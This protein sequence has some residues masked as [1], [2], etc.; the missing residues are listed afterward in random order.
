MS[1]EIRT[2]L[3]AIAGVSQL[4]KRSGL[5]DKQQVQV[6]KIENAGRH[7]LEII[8]A[9]LDLSKIEAGKFALEEEALNI[10][11]ILSN[12]TSMLVDRAHAKQLKLVIEAP[13]LPRHLLGDA[14]RI[15]QAL[16]NYLTN[17]IKFTDSGTVTLRVQIAQRSDLDVLLRFEV[18]DTGMG[19]EPEQQARLFSVFEQAD[20][21]I[22][23]RFGGTGL[24]LAITRRLAQL[25]GGNAGVSSEPGVG[26]TFWFTA[27]LK[28]F[29]PI[30]QLA[31]ALD[32]GSAEEQLSRNFSGSRILLAEDEPVN[33]EIAVSYLEIVG[34]SVES[35]ADGVQAVAMAS[36]N[37]YDLVLMDV[38]MPH[39]DGL[40]ATRRIR[41]RYCA[42]E[43][44]IIA[45]TANAFVEDKSR[46]L[47]AGMNDFV[48]KPI[49]IEQFFATML[50]WLSRSA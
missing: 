23:R 9:I 34:M 37:D 48:A 44:P 30:S 7:L 49:E 8:N 11:E 3:S 18:Q 17:A 13:M 43:L 42:A 15:R 46:C 26:S 41:E 31:D 25:M 32:V 29:T 40:E 22:A 50:K 10:E 47:D 2:P 27:R 20:N 33:R 16:L 14:T 35:A 28:I 36:Q 38:Q 19:I 6:D 21:S 45:M 39:L 12:A 1:H 24:G 4:L 5:S